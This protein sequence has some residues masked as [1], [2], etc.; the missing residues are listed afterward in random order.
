MKTTTSFSKIRSNR[1]KYLK[2]FP[3]FIHDIDRVEED[4]DHWPCFEAKIV[5]DLIMIPDVE[6]GDK[7]FRYGSFGKCE[8]VRTTTHVS[9]S[10]PLE[11]IPNSRKK[12]EKPYRLR[13]I[14]FSDGN[15]QQMDIDEDISDFEKDFLNELNQKMFPLSYG[16]VREQNHDECQAILQ[17]TKIY[18]TSS[19]INS[20]PIEDNNIEISSSKLLIYEH[21]YL[22]PEETIFLQHALGCLIVKDEFN[23][24][25]SPD[26]LWNRFIIKDKNFSIKYAVYYQYRSIGWVVKCGLKFGCDYMLYKFGPTFSHANYCL[27]I[28]NFWKTNSCTWSFISGFNRACLNA[29]KTLLV[30]NVELPKVITNNIEE[31]LEQTKI[32]KSF[33]MTWLWWIIIVSIIML[34]LYVSN[35]YYWSGTQCPSHDRMDGKTVVITGS[36]TG[37]GKYTAIELARRGA[38][39]ILAC[40]DRDR[41]Q[42]ALKDIRRISGN[43]NVEI[44][45]LDLASLKS[46]RECAKQLRGRLIKLDVLINNAGVMMTTGKSVDGYEIH[47]ASNHLGH[48]LL[49]NLLLDLMKKAPSARVINVSSINHAFLNC[50]INWDD[51]NFEKPHWGIN[52]YSHSKLA[53]ILF[54]NELARRL[55][56]T[57]ITANSLH[58][59]VARSEVIRYMCGRYQIILNFLLV[60]LTPIWWCFT[61]NLEQSAQTSIYLACDRHLEN[62]TGKYFSDCKERQSSKISR[63][64]QSAERLWKLSAEM[65]QLNDALKEVRD[66]END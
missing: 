42:D 44:E 64:E 11:I 55:K 9:P 41:A 57:N 6:H 16:Q 56:G 2:L 22:L 21:V 59:G 53:N 20:K 40:R 4:E 3:L 14:E 23:Q 46:V 29:G 65:T 37:I 17:Q 61:K 34:V 7:L 45:M 66:E 47:F 60:L 43:N 27:S 13:T 5:D 24:I 30:A 15:S 1:I 63:D 51:I 54:T 19:T 26:E 50:T 52:A 38:H 39:V 28:E 10:T 33:I 35:K 49:T 31:F 32:N 62:V 18:S 36:N 12:Y 8:F 48:F 58:P 25:L